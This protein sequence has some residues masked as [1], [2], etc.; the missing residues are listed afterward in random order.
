MVELAQA[1]HYYSCI[2]CQPHAIYGRFQGHA[3]YGIT[4]VSVYASRLRSVVDACAN[5]GKSGDAR[6]KYFLSYVGEFDP[7]PSKA[8]RSELP[9]VEVRT[10]DHDSVCAYVYIPCF[11]SDKLDALMISL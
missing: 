10:M 1:R 9:S 4:S 5:A 8:L 11:T 2:F 3:V 6:D 7:Y